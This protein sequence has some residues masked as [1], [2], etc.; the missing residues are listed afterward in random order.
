MGTLTQR[1]LQ[2]KFA[3]LESCCLHEA[4]WRPQDVARVI[5]HHEGGP[6]GGT[7]IVVVELAD[8]GFGV[9]ISSEDYTGHG[10]R[11]DSATVRS[12]SLQE[13]LSHLTEE[14]RKLV[15]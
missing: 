4:Q 1:Q 11:C 2:D 13:A 7:D 8:G 9:M 5:A 12:G 6:D 3:F 15:Q 14:E 10:C